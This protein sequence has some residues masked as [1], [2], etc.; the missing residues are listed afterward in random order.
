MLL[1]VN[2]K[3]Q[4]ACGRVWAMRGVALAVVAGLA[5]GG[6]TARAETIGGALI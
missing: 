5:L 1:R 6:A 4:R 2:L 3:A